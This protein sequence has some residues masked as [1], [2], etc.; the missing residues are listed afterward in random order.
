LENASAIINLLKIN[1]IC[2]V[3]IMLKKKKKKNEKQTKKP[4]CYASSE[5]IKKNCNK[6]TSNVKAH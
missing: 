6:I 5:T 1:S 3:T 2:I 4:Q